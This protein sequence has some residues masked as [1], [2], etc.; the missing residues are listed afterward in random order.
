MA[1]IAEVNRAG[2]NIAVADKPWNDCHPAASNGYVL[3][4]S[5]PGASKYIT[6]LISGNA[7]DCDTASSTCC[8]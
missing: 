8:R 6:A 5:L 4:P 2:W 1:A 7:P 3:F